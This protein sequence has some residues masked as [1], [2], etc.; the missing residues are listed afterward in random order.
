MDKYRID[1][2]KLMF[3][4][5]RV[6]DWLNGKPIYPIYIEVSP[7]GSCNH[8]CTYCGLDFMKYRPKFLETG[9]FKKRLVEMGKCGVKSIMYAGEGEPFL[10][11][12]MAEIT[13]AT[14]KA[15]IDVAFTTNGAL[16][17]K[18]LAENILPYASWIKVSINAGKP[19]TYKKIHRS[20]SG[21]FERVFENMSYAAELRDK[22]GYN[23]TLGMQ[24]VL[25]P[26]NSG[27]VE[28]LAEK[29]K[30]IGMDYLVVKP[31]SQH[32]QSKTRIF[33]DIKY[34]K[35]YDMA[36]SLS[37]YND[38]NFHIVFRIHAMQ[39]WDGADKSYK[40]CLALPFWSYI[41]SDGNVWACSIYLTDKKFMIGNIYKDSFGQIYKSDKY[42]KLINRAGKALDTSKCRV[43]CRMDEINRYLWELKNPSEHVNFI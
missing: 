16:F 41:D 3:H 37:R 33:K 7:S 20:P 1:S 36:D 13:K 2:H 31:Y 4:T 40:H 10:H 28:L 11:K 14:K 5:S 6:N 15:G 17:N 30:E 19:A 22:K 42:K 38:K 18:G 43:N 8:R 12:D 39:K 25:L 34:S 35:Y 23:C 24:L 9:V 27:E 32:P 29:A 21:D 26:Q